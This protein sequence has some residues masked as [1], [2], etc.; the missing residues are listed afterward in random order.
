MSAWIHFLCDSVRLREDIFHRITI[1]LQG[2][3]S[4][5]DE[6]N[7]PYPSAKLWLRGCCEIKGKVEKDRETWHSIGLG[8]AP[9]AVITLSYGAANSY[10]TFRQIHTKKY[11]IHYGTLKQIGISSLPG[12]PATSA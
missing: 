1:R 3:F 6:S 12:P 11:K 5:Y 9:K 7:C 10:F 8:P 2:F 4:L